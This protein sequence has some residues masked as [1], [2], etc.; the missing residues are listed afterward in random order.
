[1]AAQQKERAAASVV[2]AEL[3]VS[4]SRRQCP[5]VCPVGDGATFCVKRQGHEGDH[6]G[7]RAQ[8]ND[9]ERVPITEKM[10]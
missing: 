1:M 10:P 6:R 5:S 9:Q 4:G 2:I 8:W 7:Y 3:M